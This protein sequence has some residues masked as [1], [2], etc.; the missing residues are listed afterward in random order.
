MPLLP[1]INS[2]CKSNSQQTILHSSPL[3]PFFTSRNECWQ[4]RGED[5]RRRVVKERDQRW[6]KISWKGRLVSPV[7]RISKAECLVKMSSYWDVNFQSPK[8]FKFQAKPFVAGLGVLKRSAQHVYQK[9]NLCK[10][11]NRDARRIQNDR[12]KNFPDQEQFVSAGDR[13]T[14][15][16][17]VKL[18]HLA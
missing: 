17:P 2:A 10:S 3:I 4:I 8:A 14:R 11:G 1:L 7:I 5:F 16:E 12:M 15:G 18:L 9:F 6:R 13:G